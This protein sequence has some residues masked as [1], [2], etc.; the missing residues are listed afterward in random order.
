M[1]VKSSTKGRFFSVVNVLHWSPR[2]E[3]AQRWIEMKRELLHTA[4]VSGDIIWPAKRLF[5][6][7]LSLRPSLIFCSITASTLPH[8][9][10]KKKYYNT[11]FFLLFSCSSLT[12]AYEKSCVGGR[13]KQ[14]DCE[15]WGLRQ[16]HPRSTSGTKMALNW[17]RA[18]RSKFPRTAGE[19]AHPLIHTS[20]THPPVLDVYQT[21]LV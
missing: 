18:K 11:I 2:A 21:F 15:V 13:R 4:S 6:I 10:D 12:Q 8:V 3:R 14:A 16:P 9:D 20:R 19:S 5:W 1:K 17:R 7:F